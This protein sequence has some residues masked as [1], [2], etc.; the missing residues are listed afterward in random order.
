MQRS[1]AGISGP[2]GSG[3]VVFNLV[4]QL[5]GRVDLIQCTGSSS[6]TLDMLVK[7]REH[8]L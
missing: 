2:T 1:K 5:D 8:C 6:S 4:A 3:E 7:C